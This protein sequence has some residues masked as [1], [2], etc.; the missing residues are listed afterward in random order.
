M[1]GLNTLILMGAFGLLCA[2]NI[3]TF[4]AFRHDKNCAIRNDT[5]IPESNLLAFAFF[6]GWF[7]AKMAQKGY[8]HKTRKELFRTI[9]NFVP[10]V[11]C[12]LGVALW[13]ELWR[14][15]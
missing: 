5:R 6:G 12:L 4:L 11:W 2:V 3:L 14:W 9:L 10:I 13:F 7:G 1:S 15:L 8:R